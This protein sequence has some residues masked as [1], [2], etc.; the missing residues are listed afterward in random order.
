MKTPFGVIDGTGTSLN[1][2]I[3]FGNTSKAPTGR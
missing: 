3:D 1:L 2:S